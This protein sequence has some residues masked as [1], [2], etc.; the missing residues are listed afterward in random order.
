MILILFLLISVLILSYKI[1]E[2]FSIAPGYKKGF[3][4]V[5]DENPQCSPSGNCFKGSCVRSQ[6]SQN[7]CEPSYGLLKQKKSLQTHCLSS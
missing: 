1:K 3:A 7:F 4:Y 5:Y 2:N 6:A